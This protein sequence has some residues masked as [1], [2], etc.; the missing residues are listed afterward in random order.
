[1]KLLTGTTLRDQ[2]GCKFAITIRSAQ[3][4]CSASHF[5]IGTLAEKDGTVINMVER[6]YEARNNKM[7]PYDG[8]LTDAEIKFIKSDILKY[9]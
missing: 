6:S 2:G 4:R 7:S 1:M 8:S 3:D 5:A 9:L